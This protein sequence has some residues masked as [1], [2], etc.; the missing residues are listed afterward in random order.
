M[1]FLN[2]QLDRVALAAGTVC[3]FGFSAGAVVVDDPGN[4]RPMLLPPTN[5]QNAIGSWGN[6]ASAVAIGPNH[7]LTTRHQDGFSANPPLRQVTLNGTTYNSV[8]Q[9]LFD[10]AGES[11]DVRLVEI[12]NTDGSAADLTDFVPV[13]TRAVGESL[14]G[15]RTVLAAHG[16]TGIN[17]AAEGFD[18]APFD[19]G[20]PANSYGLNFGENVIDGT[21]TQNDSNFNGGP[22]WVSDF[23][24][25]GT[26]GALTYEASVAPG[27]SGGAALL[28]R[29]DQWWLVG[30]PNAVEQDNSGVLPE[31]FFGQ[32]LFHSDVTVLADDI[33]T[34]IGNGFA[35]PDPKPLPEPASAVLLAAAGTLL[36]RRR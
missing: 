20:T 30:L 9:T 29:Y 28:F 3:A 35:F 22:R 23:D 10:P 26:G 18:W 1:L 25:P 4:A 27:D 32:D 19:S 15:Q 21:D 5:I 17:E 16:V 14:I 12:Q 13:Y 11:W 34:A 8:S 24:A 36:R 6:N 7:V 33:E 2:R 31:A